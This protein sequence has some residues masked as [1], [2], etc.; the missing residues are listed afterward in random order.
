MKLYSKFIVFIAFSFITLFVISFLLI[1]SIPENPIRLRYSF[2]NNKE[3]K[4][5]IPQ[6]WSFFTKNPREEEIYIYDLSN[7]LNTKIK[8]NNIQL[9]QLFGIKRENRIIYTKTST[10]FQN[11]DASLLIDFK[12]DALGFIQKEENMK[13]LNEVSV[14]VRKPSLCGKYLIEVKQPIAWSWLSIKSKVKMPS[15]LIIIDFKC[16]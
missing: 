7:S 6:G 11:I 10:V 5:L 8:L 13:T 1:T 3:M 4:Y 9:N 14:N 12:G 2:F 16:Y 15:K